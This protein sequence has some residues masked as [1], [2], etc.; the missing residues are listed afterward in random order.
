MDK[1][2]VILV[3]LFLV[4]TCECS[5]AGDNSWPLATFAKWCS[6]CAATSPPWD[7]SPARW[8]PFCKEQTGHSWSRRLIYS[9]IT[10][11]KDQV[12]LP[13]APEDLHQ[14][15]QVGM[16]Q[17][18][19]HADFP[20]GD[21][22]NE[23]VIFRL[24]ELL[25]GHQCARVP[26]PALVHSA[27]AAFANLADLLVAFNHAGRRARPAKRNVNLWLATGHSWSLITSFPLDL[28]ALNATVSRFCPRLKTPSSYLW[29]PRRR[30]RIRA[31]RPLLCATIWVRTWR[32]TWSRR[33]SFLSYALLWHSDLWP[34]GR[35]FAV[36]YSTAFSQSMARKRKEVLCVLGLT[37]RL[38][39]YFV[40]SSIR[41][42]AKLPMRFN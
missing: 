31:D 11:F 28:L 29:I 38:E 36:F 22:L 12:Q 32:R 15:D 6:E 1:V 10:V 16:L 23:R 3:V 34:A 39:G 42:T 2:V 17:V 25:D 9:L 14:I 13:L 18:L 41:E 30:R 40:L 33:T 35:I 21:L 24:L 4:L 20:H 8:G 7:F 5:C 37:I 27:V 26:R 19:Q